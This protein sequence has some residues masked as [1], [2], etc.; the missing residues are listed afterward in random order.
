[1]W[2]IFKKNIGDNMKKSEISKYAEKLAIK[3]LNCN[4][5]SVKYMGGGSFGCVF[6]LD[7]DKPPYTV[8][9]K[10]CLVSGMNKREANDTTL[11]GDGCPIK[12]PGIY[13]T[14]DA[15]NDIPVDFICMEF[16]KGK[17]TFTNHFLLLK[18][19]NKKQKFANEVT[20]AMNFWHSKTNAKF[21]D[22]DNA[23]Y[24]SWLDY[25]KPFAFD[26]LINAE[27]LA[28]ENKLEK[29]VLDTMKRAW[30]NF[31]YIFSEKVEKPAL[32]HGDL[33]VMNIM[34]DNNLNPVAIIDPLNSKWADKEYDLFQLRNL[35]GDKFNLYETYKAKYKVSEKC[36]IK[37]AFYALYNEV[38]CYITSGNK[39]NFI[40]KPL[41]KRMNSVLD[42]I[43]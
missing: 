10:A 22:T 24:D 20:S 31:S 36:D 21:G 39:Y 40:L 17:D 43:Q 28:K 8:V 33:N 14:F 23:I 34:S 5:K 1:M 18:S 19:K 25:Y 30:N 35:T 13:F 27:K 37:C 9:M 7:I 4:V 29:N 42:K 32:I 26:I 3:K 6:K 15:D 16:I 12:M 2:V 11:L 41:V 38:Y